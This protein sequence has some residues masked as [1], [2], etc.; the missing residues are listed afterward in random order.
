M[1]GGVIAV[2]LIVILS[3]QLTT[4]NFSSV[5]SWIFGYLVKHHIPND[6]SVSNPD[7]CPDGEFYRYITA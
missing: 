1:F 6:V 7:N 3:V 4:M 2:E 5:L